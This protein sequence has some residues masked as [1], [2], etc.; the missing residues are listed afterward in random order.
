MYSMRDKNVQNFTKKQVDS[1]VAGG[2]EVGTAIYKVLKK[3][4]NVKIIDV[5]DKDVAETIRS[6]S[7]KTLH[8]AFPF[9]DTDSFVRNCMCYIGPMSPELIIIHSTVKVGVTD[10][11]QKEALRISSNVVS[12]VHSPVRGTHPDLEKSLKHFVKY[13]GTS[14][15]KA[16]LL[17]KAELKYMPT[18][19]IKDSRATELGKLLDTSYYG[20]CI[21]WHR[22]MKR[23]CNKLNIN[24]SDAV[25]DMNTTYNKGYSSLR[26]NVIR[27]V[28]LPPEGAIGGHCVVPNAKL[29]NSQIKS[30]FLKLIH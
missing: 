7:C 16:Y 21:S 28:L 29:L 5:K 11:V 4:K 25:T 2:G 30:E 14:S 3:H 19:W 9:V 20:V 23:I 15:K 26:N 22:E 17:A 18:K 12:V 24:Y 1:I 13:V 6:Y 27:P 10:Q 8:I